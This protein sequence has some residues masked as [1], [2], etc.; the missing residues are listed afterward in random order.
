MDRNPLVISLDTDL[1]D[2]VSNL[3]DSNKKVA[4]VMD[5]SNVQG[6]IKL[7]DLCYAL[8]VYILEKLFSENIPLDIRKIEVEKLMHNPTLRD[9]CEKCGF[10]KQGPTISVEEENTVADAIQV[11]AT[12]GLDTL[13][14]KRGNKEPSILTDQ[15]VI[16]IF[17]K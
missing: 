13:L 6:I 11:M 12:S 10:N 1:A 15:D 4:I 7:S 2:V 14:V 8:K 16:Q 17:K 5:G 9:I 3:A